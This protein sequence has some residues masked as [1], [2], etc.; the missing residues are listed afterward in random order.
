MRRR[1]A[2]AAAAVV[3]VAIVAGGC[4]GG[5]DEGGDATSTEEAAASEL[6]LEAT[7]FAFSPATLSAAAGAEVT[8]TV[9][10]TGKAPHTFTSEALDVDEQVDAGK[11]AEVTF[12]MPD[13]GTV[14]FVCTFHEGQG[15][16]GSITAG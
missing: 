3:T 1:G 6:E 16:K 12:T 7:D 4:G 9:R 11:S 2:W 10:N 13:S 8:L 14:D 15:M 5:D